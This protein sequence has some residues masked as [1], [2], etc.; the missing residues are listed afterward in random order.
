MVYCLQGWREKMVA[1]PCPVTGP[2]SIACAGS[3]AGDRYC[4][5]CFVDRA[6]DIDGRLF[7]ATGLPRRRLG[8]C[9]AATQPTLEVASPC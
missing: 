9:Q 5:P 4:G 6:G 2:D 3:L 1:L 8:P 7:D